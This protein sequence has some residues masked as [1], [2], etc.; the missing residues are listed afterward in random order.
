MK[1]TKD[2]KNTVKPI[3]FI[4]F[5]IHIEKDNKNDPVFNFCLLFTKQ[6]FKYEDDKFQQEKRSGEKNMGK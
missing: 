4:Q 6:K 5:P 3:Q 1:T 2:R